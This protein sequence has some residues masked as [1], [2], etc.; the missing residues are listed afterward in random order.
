MN[1][2]QIE[3][4]LRTV[5]GLHD[6]KLEPVSEVATP[7]FYLVGNVLLHGEPYFF[8]TEIKVTEFHTND[9]VAQLGA[10]LLAAV[11]R[12]NQ[13]AELMGVQAPN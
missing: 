5:E 7:Y 8:K 9:D 2:Q 1:A 11:L 3:S 13:R 6:I 12:A 4:K 10:S